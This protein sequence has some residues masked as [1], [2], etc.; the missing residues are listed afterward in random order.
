M[1]RLLLIPLIVASLFG[2]SVARAESVPCVTTIHRSNFPA[3]ARDVPRDAQLSLLMYGCSEPLKAVLLRD[4]AAVAAEVTAR[5]A[6]GFAELVAVKPTA[7]LDAN[8]TYSLV[9]SNSSGAA[10][11]SFTT[12]ARLSSENHD[13]PTLTLAAT[14]Y[15]A[16]IVGDRRSR[17]DFDLLVT[18]N[19]PEAGGVITVQMQTG[20]SP[21]ATFV[22]DTGAPTTIA[23]LQRNG[24]EGEQLCF[25][26]TYTDLAGRVSEPSAAV[27]HTIGPEPPASGCSMGV[28]RSPAP[29]LAIAALGI[30]LAR[31]GRSRRAAN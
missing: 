9:V 14:R 11:L 15:A 20:A 10:T 28:Q 26:A 3:G 21:L 1:T 17:V 13:P 19:A 18:P 8:T 23:R 22:F 4:G 30:V 16:E 5:S 25:T 12:G 31:R 6:Q 27:C 29:W 2:A 24:L 7:P